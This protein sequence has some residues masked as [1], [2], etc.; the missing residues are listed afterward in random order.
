[1]KYTVRD[2]V[3]SFLLI[4]GLLFFEPLSAMSMN[5]GDTSKTE[6]STRVTD[7]LNGE[8]ISNTKDSLNLVRLP[9]AL[10]EGTLLLKTPWEQQPY[11]TVLQKVTQTTGSFSR[12]SPE[13]L[14]NLTGVMVQKTNH[15][16]G[17]P[18][19]RG[20][21][22]NQTL[23]L[24]DG[25]RLN[26]SIFRYGPNQYLNTVD[27]FGLDQMEVLFGNGAVQ[28]GSDAM[29]GTILA[30]FH[31]PSRQK[32][33][34][35]IVHGSVRGMSDNQEKSG[36]ASMDYATEKF[37]V[38]LGGTLRDF[39]D[40]VAGGDRLVLNPTGYREKNID[41]KFQVYGKHG[42]WTIAHQNNNQFDVPVFH[43]VALE[44]YT[45]Y[46]MDLQLRALTY[47]RRE[48]QQVLGVFERV[49]LTGGWQSQG[50]WR[51]SQKTHPILFVEKM[52]LWRHG[53]PH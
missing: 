44:N 15:G 28:Y 24:V 12:T 2:I 49:E 32:L 43:K 5:L 25:I 46:K 53:L 21:Q 9:M 17:S 37:G 38:T 11:R 31:E 14:M 34:Q 39:G 50:E 40:V 1:M 29:S 23:M 6:N 51:S 48:W 41:A 33:N 10:V 26:N 36:R 45:Y 47:V 7:L 8:I 30:K 42:Q 18:T 3:I 13:L 52:I 4:G 16:G 22:G 27:A 35:W 20:L 19:L